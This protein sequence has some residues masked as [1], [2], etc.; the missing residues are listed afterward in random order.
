MSGL[1][2]EPLA[3][4]WFGEVVAGALGGT[5]SEFDLVG[6]PRSMS[7]A[8]HARHSVLLRANGTRIDVSLPFERS[9]GIASVADW[10]RAEPEVRSALAGDT[11]PFTLADAVVGLRR[12]LGSIG[13]GPWIVEFEAATVPASASLSCGP[14]HVDLV[15]AR[16]GVTL[17]VELPER[18][19][20][21]RIAHTAE[22]E[23]LFPWLMNALCLQGIANRPAEVE[24]RRQAGLP[25]PG[26]E[27]VLRA[28]QAGMRINTGVS[29]SSVTFFWEGGLRCETFD[30]D[31]GRSLRDSS[32]AELRA[33]LEREPQPFRRALGID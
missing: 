18:L 5:T 17:V 24:R 30:I 25:K 4:P 19:E 2:G 23:N 27:A 16:D 12:V 11:W 3:L 7:I 29:R 10:E 32:E 9:W 20:P 8:V 26:F 21:Q 13:K 1:R 31:E 22:L 33:T 14:L 15:Q 28:L 6:A